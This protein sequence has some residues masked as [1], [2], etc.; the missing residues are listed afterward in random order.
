ML[1]DGRSVRQSVGRS[2]SL[3]HTTASSQDVFFCLHTFPPSGRS[4]GEGGGVTASPL[5]ASVAKN[6]LASTA[7]LF[8]SSCFVTVLLTVFIH[9]AEMRGVCAEKNPKEMELKY[10][11]TMVCCVSRGEQ[12]EGRAV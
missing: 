11:Q 8:L 9:P 4:H 3:L 10:N 2:V 12:E 1:E 6:H 7:V 5:T